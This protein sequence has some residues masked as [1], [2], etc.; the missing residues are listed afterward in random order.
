MSGAKNMDRLP[1]HSVESEQGVLGCVLLS[2]EG[3]LDALVQQRVTERT[4]YDLRH[5]LIFGG[6]LRLYRAHLPVDLI[7]LQQSL[8]DSGVLDEVGGVGYLSELEGMTPS[9]ANL[10]YY[11]EVVR[12]KYRLRTLISF[13]TTAVARVYECQGKAEELMA[14]L[15]GELEELCAPMVTVAERHIKAVLREDVLPLIERHYSRGQTQLDGL[16]TGLSYLDKTMLGIAPTDYVVLAARPGEGKTSL[17]LNVVDYVATKYVWWRPVGAE[18][19]KGLAD[20]SFNEEQQSYAQRMV[21]VPVAV[22]TLEMTEDSLGMRLVFSHARVSSGSFRQGFAKTGDFDGVKRSV[23]ELSA[24][25][26]YLDGEADQTMDMIAAKARRMVRQHGIKLFVLDYLQL[27]DSDEDNDRLRVLR[28]ISKKIV[29]LKKRLRVP[30]LVLAQMNRNIETA[31]RARRPVLSDLKESGSI[32]QDADKIV[33]LYHPLKSEGVEE[34]EEMIAEVWK[35]AACDAPRRINALVA[36]NRNGPT[37]PAALLFQN[38]QCLFQDW[39]EWAV[40]HGFK[41][42]AKG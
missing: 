7:S 16:P 11:S 14:G 15:E 20:V 4:F 39:R 38:N 24:A 9:A 27:L 10:G 35:G 23:S 37:G 36:K 22:F 34:D 2:P 3:V 33:F 21:G 31:E 6:M 25:N 5:Q 29:S 17:G 12:E 30:W 26:I 19:A 13:C 42:R 18:E 1:P 28:R 8:R 41:D 40:A 32:E